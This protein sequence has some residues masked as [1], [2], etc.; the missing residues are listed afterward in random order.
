[1]LGYR[2]GGIEVY[3]WIF[4]CFV[5]VFLC[6]VQLVESTQEIYCEVTSQEYSFAMNFRKVILSNATI[7]NGRIVITDGMITF[8]HY[9]DSINMN[10]VRVRETNSVY[11]I[12]R[13]PCVIKLHSRANKAPYDMTLQVVRKI[14]H[15]ILTPKNAIELAYP[16]VGKTSGGEPAVG[17][18]LDVHHGNTAPLI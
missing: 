6:H 14:V 4:F 9:T 12:E 2:G 1:M 13:R 5:V 18:S 3:F 11:T 7:K 17:H 15:T 10:W 8:E 16:S